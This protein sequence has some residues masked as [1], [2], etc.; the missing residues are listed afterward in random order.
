MGIR[1]SD[2]SILFRVWMV[3]TSIERFP[4]GSPISSNIDRVNWPVVFRLSLG[5]R[6]PAVAKIARPGLHSST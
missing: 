6:P 2:G 1:L 3:K 4:I 5:G